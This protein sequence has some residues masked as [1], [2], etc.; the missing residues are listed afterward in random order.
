MCP[1]LF[2]Y[3]SFQVILVLLSLLRF[4]LLLFGF[5]LGYPFHTACSYP[6]FRCHSWLAGQLYTRYAQGCNLRFSRDCAQQSSSYASYCVQQCRPLLELT[7]L[8]ETMYNF[9]SIIKQNVLRGQCSKMKEHPNI[10]CLCNLVLYDVM[11]VINDLSKEN[12]N[13]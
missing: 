6:K 10:S 12:D 7:E 9:T 5:F 2:R 4:L 13:D 11:L 1:T 3:I 8:A